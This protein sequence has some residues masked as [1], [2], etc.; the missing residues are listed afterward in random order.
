[1]VFHSGPVH[2]YFQKE[3]V[4]K[5]FMSTYYLFDYIPARLYILGRSSVEEVIKFMPTL[6]LKTEGLLNKPTPPMLLL[7]GVQ[8]PQTPYS[9]LLI[10]LGNGSPKEAWVNPGGGH[11]GRTKD[12]DDQAIFEQVVYPWVLRQLEPKK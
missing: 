1:V 8:D 2:D 3:W 10:L 5:S 12:M 11:M 9:D 4:E 7:A 6:S